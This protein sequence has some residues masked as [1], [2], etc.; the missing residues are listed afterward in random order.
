[1]KKILLLLPVTIL[2]FQTSFSQTPE[3]KVKPIV[4]IFTDFHVN[5]NDTSKTTGFGL[6]RAYFG[7]NLETANNFSSTIIVNIGNP[8]DLP[9]SSVH[10]RY[11]Y[12]REASIAYTTEKLHLSF[13]ITNTRFYDYQSRFWGK[14]YIANTFQSL[15]GYGVV[16]DL[17]IVADY[18][19]SEIVTADITIMNGEG[20][21]EL[22]MDNNVKT[23]MGLTITPVRQ[24][25]VRFYGDITN[26]RGVS[27]Y[28]MNGFAGFKNQ[29]ITIGAETT[30]KT[31]LDQTS[32]HNAWGFSSTTALS[33]FNK[34]ELF[35]RFDHSASV[36]VPGELNHWNYLNDG[37]LGIIGLQ[38]TLSQNVQIALDYQET[39]P[40]DR[41]K[42]S[43]DLIYLNAHFK[44]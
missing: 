35:G 16:A 37:N 10:R 33:I 20:Y 44:F 17:G 38:Y 30:Y 3:I 28:T 26:V 14:R 2:L 4:E 36:T 43:S 34:T 24:F 9:L 18:K 41:A 1:M 7:C 42:N 11:A 23:S 12:F 21:S 29:W 39:F 13:G 22:Q 19:F 5:L 40:Y 8:D 27:Q 6:N 25:S 15:N 31:N 32:G